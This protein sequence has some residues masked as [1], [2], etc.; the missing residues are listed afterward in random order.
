MFGYMIKNSKQGRAVFYAMLILFI[1]GLGVI[2]YT[3]CATNPV[4]AKIG[5]SAPVNMEGK[6]MRFGTFW[7]SLWSQS[8][9]TTSNGS[10]NSMHDSFMPLGGMIQMFN[11]GIGEV[12]F[13]GVGVGLIG[14]LFFIVLSMFVAGL[15]IGRTPEFMGKKF[16]PYEMV[17][18]MISMLLPMISMVIFSAIAISTKDGTFLPQQSFIARAFGNSLCVHVRPRKQRFGIRRPERE[19]GFLQY[20]ACCN[21][22]H[23]TLRHDN[24]RPRSGRLSREKEDRAG[25]QR[26]FPDNRAAL[27]YHS[28]QRYFHNG[29]S[30]VLP[31]LLTRPHS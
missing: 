19:H 28:Y 3:E 24:T 30:D 31:G 6:E 8:T 5:I 21:H 12:I 10:V 22:A 2:L 23:R 9:T 29:C 15:M 18:A 27:Y 16:G 20:H 7:S 17:M 1:I 4:I 25:E 26:D 11:I 13:G 14:M